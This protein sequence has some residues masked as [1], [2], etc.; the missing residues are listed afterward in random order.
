MY[1]FLM[2]TSRQ[3]AGIE[4]GSW[5]PIL[6]LVIVIILIVSFIFLEK[7]LQGFNFLLVKLL[8][9]GLMPHRN[10]IFISLI[11]LALF[12][13]FAENGDK[14][15]MGSSDMDSNDKENCIG[16]QECISKV[17]THFSNTGKTILGEQYL[18]NG[19]FGIS[20]IDSEHPDAFNATI[21]TD[22]NC[23]ITNVDVSNI[24]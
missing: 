11:I 22:C 1:K 5:I 10:K 9:D 19:R 3:S 14:S 7:L 13:F 23:E 20:F 15:K 17:R 21:N 12:L 18:G 16:N 8:P 4:I 6:T 2:M 24:R